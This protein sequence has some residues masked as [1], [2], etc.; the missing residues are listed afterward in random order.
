MERDEQVPAHCDEDALEGALYRP[1]HDHGYGGVVD[2]FQLAARVATAIAVR[3]P[4]VDGN[5]RTAYV[6][7]GVFLF[8]NGYRVTIGWG[9]LSISQQIEGIVVA[10]HSGQEAEKA[11]TSELAEHLRSVSELHGLQI[12]DRPEGRVVINLGP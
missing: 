5:K 2:I 8:M 9:D 1:H 11:A 10:S 4:F 7:M 3:H 6:T 12:V